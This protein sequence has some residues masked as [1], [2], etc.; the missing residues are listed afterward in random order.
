MAKDGE[1]LYMNI[2]IAV[3]STD[4]KIVNQHFGRANVFYILLVNAE[5]NTYEY[6]EKRELTPICN[7][8]THEDSALYTNIESLKDCQYILVSKVGVRAQNE[9][10]R[11]GIQVYEISGVIEESVNQL[12]KYVEIQK[13]I[14]G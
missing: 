14:Y 5:E 1:N 7:G 13:L 3:A 8:G 9:I 2:K 4:G 11:R 10:E 6:L 12:L